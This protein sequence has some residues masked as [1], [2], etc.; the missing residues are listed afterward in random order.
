MQKMHEVFKIVSPRH[1][2]ASRSIKCKLSN[3]K[4]QIIEQIMQVVQKMQV[5]NQKKK[6][7]QV[8]KTENANSSQKGTKNSSRLQKMQVI[9]QKTASYRKR[10]CK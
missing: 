4:L 5:I 3:K 7:L 10:K 8:I 1:S 9:D 2:N 6:K